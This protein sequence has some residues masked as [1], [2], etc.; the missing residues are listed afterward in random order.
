MKRCQYCGKEYADDV[1]VC[2][3]DG[4]PVIKLDE[5][6]GKI[7]VPRETARAAFDVKLVS[8]IFS[9]GTYRIFVECNDLLF[10]Q[11]EGGLR[12][13]LEAVAPLMGPAGCIIPLTLWLFTKRKA[14]SK[15]QRL[16]E[17]GPE[18]LLRGGGENFN[19][20][21]AEIRD[22][23]IEAP[24]LFSISGKIGR[25]NLFVRHGKKIKCEFV[26]AAAMRE[27]IRLLIPLLNSTLKVNV[28]WNVE[29]Q[30]YE[31]KK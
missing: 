31:K 24:T 12:S 28:E 14:K 26:N 19:L 2:P 4:Q 29:K 27:A 7:R 25:L 30:R 17:D 23:V 6:P 18:D 22:A 21:P 13:I 20:H 9:A 3:V 15:L 16:E 8:P 5:T 1:A 11:I 10:I